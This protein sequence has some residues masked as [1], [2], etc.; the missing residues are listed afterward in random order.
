MKMENTLHSETIR[1]LP[2]G[3]IISNSITV[4]AITTLYLQRNFHISFVCSRLPFPGPN[5]TTT[6]V[7]MIYSQPSHRTT[8][9]CHLSSYKPAHLPLPRFR[10]GASAMAAKSS[11]LL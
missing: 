3:L 5:S 10:T 1:V 6:N 2:L 9:H 11:Q 4:S 7:T 8:A